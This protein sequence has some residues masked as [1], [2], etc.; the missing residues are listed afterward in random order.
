MS[1]F[2][3]IVCTDKLI[4]DVYNDVY[5]FKNTI[6]NYNKCKIYYFVACD[7]LKLKEFFD[8]DNHALLPIF[9]HDQQHS[10]IPCKMNAYLVRDIIKMHLEDVGYV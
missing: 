8:C 2:Q 1:K 4:V 9:F 7:V 6:K 10:L 5:Y 3:I